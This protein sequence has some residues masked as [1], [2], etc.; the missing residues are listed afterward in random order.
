MS[1]TRVDSR[2][3]L[4]FH[5]RTALVLG[6]E[7][8]GEGLAGCGVEVVSK[9][10]RLDAPL[11]L[12]VAPARSAREAVASGASMVILEGSGA[13]R[14]NRPSPAARRFLA[15][16]DVDAPNVFVPF[17]QPLLS[18]YVLRRVLP[19]ASLVKR[20]RNEIV[21]V[22]LARAAIPLEDR[23]VTITGSRSGLPFLVSAAAHRLG[24]ELSGYV[25]APHGGQ[26]KRSLFHL[27]A[28][29]R[30]EPHAV[31]KF[32]RTKGPDEALAAQ[33]RGLELAAA[34]GR[35]VA[36]RV[37]R[38]LAHVE[39]EG[40]HALVESAVIGR[41]LS[42]VLESSEPR[43]Q[44][45]ARIEA[46]ASWLTDVARSTSQPPEALEPARRWFE[47]EIVPRWVES[48]APRD[49]V[50]T[51]PRV[52]AALQH[53][54]LTPANVIASDADFAVID[55]EHANASWFPLVDIVRFLADALAIV[56]GAGG[57]GEARIEHF[58][59][60]FRG[61]LSASRVLFDAVSRSVAASGVAPQAVG[62]IA[63]LGWLE[64]AAP[65]GRWHGPRLARAWLSDPA[66][67]PGWSRWRG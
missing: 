4:P 9:A 67:G 16:P 38:A 15:W 46:V 22:L 1:S 47:V 41:N 32:T 60:L 3:L 42:R 57:T 40:F 36:Q 23:I 58:I 19:A 51:I 30:S 65:P 21:H 64:R 2:F 12:V 34:A 45:L 7:G 62:P 43:S 59:R 48:G 5:P 26:R 31:L 49:L 28:T 55:W 13:R 44:K 14:V 52:P 18:R 39:S 37:P 20:L 50:A 61:E 24:L 63:T 29:G 6:L 66:L 8:W 53:R 11:D 35:L 54:D 10:S 33:A 25:F 17:G 56:D 27:F